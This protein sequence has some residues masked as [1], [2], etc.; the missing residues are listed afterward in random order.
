MWEV[1]SSASTHAV[2][3]SNQDYLSAEQSYDGYVVVQF[4]SPSA[5]EITAAQP[6]DDQHP[7]TKSG[8]KDTLFENLAS[9]P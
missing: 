4:L 3:A 6:Y 5:A 9:L 1:G 7:E 8:R 2:N